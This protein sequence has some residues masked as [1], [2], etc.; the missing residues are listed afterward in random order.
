MSRIGK[1]PIKVSQGVEVFVTPE[2]IS[3]K[4]P[5]GELSLSYR[6]EFIDVVVNDSTVN[7]KRNSDD[8]GVRALH[9]LTR[10]LISNAV[11]GVESGFSKFL[12]IHGV[13]FRAELQG[14]KLTLHI[15][16]SHVVE[17]EAP[18]GVDLA[19]VDPVGGAQARI[20]ISGIDK[21]KVGQV[22]AEIR[23]KR[24]PDP[25]RGKGI[26]YENEVIHWKAGKTAVA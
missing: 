23:E 24:K 12:D 13:G 20:E 11:T 16:Y 4:G 10:S 14:R 17:Y 9:G 6:S 19:T 15:G 3:V 18:D 8:K 7:V 25:Y 21:Q 5:K 22:A 1:Q 2:A 26:R